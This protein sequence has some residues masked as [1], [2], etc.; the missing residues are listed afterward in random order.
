MNQSIDYTN[1]NFFDIIDNEEKA[2]W[3]G[4]IYAD[5]CIS[6]TEKRPNYHVRITLSNKD[7]SHLEK[8]AKIFNIEI[9]TIPKEIAGGYGASNDIVRI[10]IYNKDMWINLYEIGIDS[11]KT[12]DEE[13][14]IL[15]NI[16]DELLRHFIRGVFD[17]DGSIS[18]NENKSGGKFNICGTFGLMEKLQKY[19]I[20]NLEL[21]ETKLVQHIK[22]K[23][24]YNLA[25]HGVKQ[26]R[27]IYDWFYQDS[28]VFLERKKEIF[29]K[30][31][32]GF[33]RSQAT[34]YHGA[35]FAPDRPNKQW[36][37]NATINHIRTNLGRFK[38]DLECA[39]IFDMFQIQNRSK[40]EALTHM[41]FPNM[42]DEYEEH[43]KQNGRSL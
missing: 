6:S 21:S 4:F 13:A 30:C 16:P 10:D 35:Y 23:M 15:E 3:L 18:L 41:N 5:G 8:F 9:K 24:N 36:R 27:K 31:I 26:I 34:Q 25:Y 20:E 2:Y 32:V 37:A 11:L 39:Y 42:Y 40:E 1:L 19:L 22:S 17:G 14:K 12:Y 29:E 28:T 38:T 7:K 33:K 43:I